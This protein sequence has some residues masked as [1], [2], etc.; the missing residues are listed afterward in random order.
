MKSLLY[1]IQ[2]ASYNK[3]IIKKPMQKFCSKI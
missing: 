1:Q 2:L 3:K